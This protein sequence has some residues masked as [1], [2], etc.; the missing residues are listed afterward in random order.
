MRRLILFDIDG[1]LLTAG[2]AGKRAFHDA[3]LEV[4]GTAG[5]VRG[6]S[7]AGRTDPQI[8]RELLAHEGIGAERV[9][10]ALPGFW[11]VYVRNL[12]QE[13]DPAEMRVLPGVHPLLERIEAAGNGTVLGLLT[14]N[15]VE[16]A[17]LKLDTAGIGFDRFRVGAFG[18]DHAD[19]P[20]LPAVAVARAEA[21]TGHRYKEKEI[22]VIGD[23]PFDIACGAHLGVRTLAVATGH[24]SQEELAQHGPN[25]LFADLADTE[26]VWEAIFGEG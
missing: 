5:H 11:R 8:V 15:V 3:L 12:E 16:G 6:Y 25:H 18:S 4:F 20:E 26:R 14:G 19:R 10:A 2:G 24:H 23:T 22:V 21:L 9:A 13:I 1:T 17:R 7:F